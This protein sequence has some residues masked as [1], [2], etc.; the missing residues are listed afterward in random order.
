MSRDQRDARETDARPMPQAPEAERALL[1]GVLLDGSQ[2]AELV[3]VVKPADFY[4]P[5]HGRLWALMVALER[6]GRP[7]D[8]VAVMEEIT[9]RAQVDEVGGVAYVSSLPDAA[10]STTNLG[11]YAYQV[12]DRAVRR[13][14]ITHCQDMIERVHRHDEELPELMA[15]ARSTIG[16]WQVSNESPWTPIG[17]LV[18]SALA[19]MAD[20]VHVRAAGERA[21]SLSTGLRALDEVLTMLGPGKVCVI[22]G[23]PGSGKTA[24]AAGIADH[25][26]S[27]RGS[28]GIVSLEMP[29]GEMAQRVLCAR[30]KVSYARAAK[31]RLVRAEWTR[32]HEAG[33][34]LATTPLF[35]HDAESIQS[36]TLDQRL[37]RLKAERPD[38]ALVV[39]DYLQLMGGDAKQSEEVQ[40]SRNSKALKSTAKELGICLLVLSQLNRKCEERDDKRPKLSDLRGSGSIEQD[41]DIII[42]IYR[43]EYYNPESSERGVAELNVTKQRGG[44]T[45]VKPVRVAFEGETVRFFDLEE[46]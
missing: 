34:S 13:E 39:V 6:T 9:A 45:S 4:R 1:G 3:E 36:A 41:A 43:D 26:A 8:L 18:P 29:A 46:A 25:V 10:P 11:Y 17:A 28:A 30:A 33:E 31:G 22:A 2:V 15:Y 21:G 40:I 16:Q 32:L 7:V 12:R 24:L 27:T 20:I 5:A 35:F 14:L 23:R 44:P 38:L 37:R 42:L 19:A